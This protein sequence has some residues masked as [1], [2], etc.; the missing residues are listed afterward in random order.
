MES[1]IQKNNE[2]LRDS[3]LCN[4]HRIIDANLNRLKEGLRVIEDILR[5]SFNNKALATSI[6]AL[7]HKC[8]IDNYID[9]IKQRDSTHDVLKESIND[10]MQRESLE[11]III[12]NF[13]RTQESSR[14]L[15]EIYKLENKVYSETFKNIRYELYV[16]EKQILLT[17]FNKI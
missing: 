7:R 17:F 13:K 10:E 14:V 16:L 1:S 4:N 11:N 15:E 9:I 2:N 12:A 8:K 6:K 3:H 5:Y